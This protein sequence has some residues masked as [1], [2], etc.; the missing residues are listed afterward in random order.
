MMLCSISCIVMSYVFHW[1]ISASAAGTELHVAG[2]FP[3]S[4]PGWIGEYGLQ[5]LTAV[6]LAITQINNRSDLLADYQL[7]LD[8]NDTKVSQKFNPDQ[9]NQVRLTPNQ[10]PVGPD[11]YIWIKPWP[12]FQIKPLR[13]TLKGRNCHDDS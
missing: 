5:G 6:E 9:D 10:S 13:T 7:V 11:S 1:P 3:L 12:S 4:A 2:L 8:Y